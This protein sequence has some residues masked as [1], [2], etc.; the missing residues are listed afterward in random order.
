MQVQL[1]ASEAVSHDLYM[2]ESLLA[3]LPVLQMGN[4]MSVCQELLWSKLYLQLWFGLV[5]FQM[6][7]QPS[8]ELIEQLLCI[9]S[10]VV[11]MTLLDHLLHQPLLKKHPNQQPV[12]PVLVVMPYFGGHKGHIQLGCKSY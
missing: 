8:D 9:H 3:D 7:S 4:T 10:V 11:R 1:K 12:G 6:L 2:K 5:Q